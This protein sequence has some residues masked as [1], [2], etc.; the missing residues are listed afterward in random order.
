MKVIISD[1]MGKFVN[2]FSIGVWAWCNI[3]VSCEEF[4][5][6]F[7]NFSNVRVGVK[8]LGVLINIKEAVNAILGDHAVNPDP[9]AWEL[10]FQLLESS[11]SVKETLKVT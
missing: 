6:F 9:E 10:G 1:F 7:G 4:G 5:P 3:L 8:L 11:V 2:E